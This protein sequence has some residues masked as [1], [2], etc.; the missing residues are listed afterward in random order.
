M[1]PVP[2]PAVPPVGDTA[3]EEASFL[4]NLRL[5]AGDFSG[6]FQARLELAGLEGREALG[7]Y[8]KVALMVA[9]AVFGLVFGYV[10]L[11]VGVVMALCY[12]THWPLVWPVLIVAVLHFLGAVV[13][14]LQTRNLLRTPQFQQTL[15]EFRKDRE[16]KA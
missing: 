13:F 3:A 8:I 1:P 4:R 7:H 5:W 16:W 2:D 9:L 12:F 14:L 11:M 6:F 10:F 15:A